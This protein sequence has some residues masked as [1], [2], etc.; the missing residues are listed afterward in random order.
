M[1]LSFRMTDPNGNTMVFTLPKLYFTS[2]TV[3]AGGGNDDMMV[4]LEFTAIRD[5][6]TNTV[7]QLDVLPA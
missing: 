5:V 4:P 7:A 3:A 1:S 6:A 2:A